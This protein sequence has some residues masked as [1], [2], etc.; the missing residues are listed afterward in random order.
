V[1]VDSPQGLA[2][3]IANG[4]DRIELCSALSVGGLTPSQGFMQAA[5]TAANAAGSP[6]DT[7]IVAMIRPRAGDFVY[8]SE[9]LEVMK[10]D[11]RAAR[12]A[13][14]AGVVVGASRPDGSLDANALAALVEE[15]KAP[16]GQG[17]AKVGIAMTA[18]RV[19]EWQSVNRIHFADPPQ[20]T[21]TRHQHHSKGQ[22]PCP[23]A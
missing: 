23:S 6:T 14:L 16:V 20:I 7:S 2:L 4:A 13:G 21:T 10:A 22:P 19:I 3:A 5:A 9:E 18:C 1:C 17:S 11:I 12:A 8:T 15:A